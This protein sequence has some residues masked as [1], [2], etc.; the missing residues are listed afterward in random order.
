M[1]MRIT[2]NPT[3]IEKLDRIEELERDR[4]YCGHGLGHL[5][6]V[7]RI[8]YIYSLEENLGFTRDLIYATSL[9]HDI[10]R[11][12]EYE[13]GIPHDEAG[14]VI[15]ERVLRECGYDEKVIAEVC[16]AIACHRGQELGEGG[17]LGEL[18]RRADKESRCCF[19]CGARDS[20]KWKVKNEGVMR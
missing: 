5:L 13:S 14:A 1:R 6:D 12:D 9:L 10:G 4:I 19:R 8:A 16:E 17:S 11:A 7:A 2:D 20:C 18:I 3:F 15:A